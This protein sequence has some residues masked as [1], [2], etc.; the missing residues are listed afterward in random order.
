MTTLQLRLLKQIETHPMSTISFM[1][2][3]VNGVTEKDIRVLREK[4]YVV[5]STGEG[6]IG[7]LRTMKL[8]DEG[9]QF[10]SDYCDVCE[11]M[12]CDCGYGS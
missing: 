5:L 9:L 10:I 12:P 4:G 1:D 8:T 6:Y 7:G 2:W 3:A 11:C